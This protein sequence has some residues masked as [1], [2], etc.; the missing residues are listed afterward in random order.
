MSDMVSIADSVVI[1]MPANKKAQQNARAF[2][3]SLHLLERC[4][5]FLPLV[6]F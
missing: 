5:L 2:E 1:L 3:N 6:E 4:F